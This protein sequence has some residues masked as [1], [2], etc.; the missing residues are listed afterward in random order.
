MAD[1]GGRERGFL[2]V[3]GRDVSAYLRL[4]RL[5]WMRKPSI[6]VG[7]LRPVS[8]V[9][10]RLGGAGIN[11]ESVFDVCPPVTSS[12]DGVHDLTGCGHGERPS[13]GLSGDVLL[14]TH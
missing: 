12:E 2:I 11:V 6:Q 1:V 13:A 7:R 14:D 9:D 8:T 10:W 3:Q 5:V 4:A